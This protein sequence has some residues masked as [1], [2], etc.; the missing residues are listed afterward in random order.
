MYKPKHLESVFTEICNK[1]EKNIIIGCIYKHPSMDLHEFNEDY[2]DPL[3]EKILS[4]DK[5]VF[6]M[7]DFNIDLLKVDIDTPTTNLLI[8]LHQT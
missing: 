3:M 2:L 7:G 5:E 1:N 6:L 8:Q 4:E